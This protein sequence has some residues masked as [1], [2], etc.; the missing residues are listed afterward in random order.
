MPERVEIRL[1]T[2]AA[3]DGRRLAGVAVPY[4]EIAS[5]GGMFRE[6]FEPGAF[7]GEINPEATLTVQ[8]DRAAIVARQGA[9]LTLADT[10][11]A[12]T[13][14]ADLPATP[15]ADQALADVR[16]GLLRGLSAEF[17]ALRERFEGDLR[18]VERAKLVRLSLVD[19]PAYSSAMV[20]ARAALRGP[21]MA[22]RRR[23]W[24]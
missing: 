7:T 11:G 23:V 3:P 1:A 18:V 9:G 2:L 16:A 5:I 6:R 10:P 21:Q 24:L 8:H 14:A 12:V 20:E 4:G 22:G 17:V 15:R 19:S 13:M